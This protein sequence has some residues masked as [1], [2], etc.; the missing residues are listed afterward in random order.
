MKR[1]LAVFFTSILLLCGCGTTSSASDLSGEQIYQALTAVMPDL[2][3][4]DKT[5]VVKLLGL[6]P[7][8]LSNAYAAFEKNGGPQLLIVLEST[9][10]D[11]ALAAAERMNYYLSSLQN[12]AAQYTP[13]QSELLNN[14]YVY[15]NG[16]YS[17]MAVS[18]S[19][20]QA[21]KELAK[22]FQ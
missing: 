11:A 5:I 6:D 15:T 2:E 14:G 16:V 12:S 22:L 4:Q 3:P 20:D 21:K 19:L 8:S 18:D 9:D 1:I 10:E 17:I 7:S 13:E